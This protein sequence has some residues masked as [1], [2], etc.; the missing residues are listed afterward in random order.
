M[1]ANESIPAPAAARPG[2]KRYIP[3][4][5]IALGATAGI[6]FL[7][8][9]LSFSALEENYEAL[10]AW[11]DSNFLI[12]ALVFFLAYVVVVAFSIPGA[13]WL[14]LL[15]G[16]LFGL[17]MGTA[18]VIGSATLGAT[19]IFLAARTSL[20]ALLKEKAGK[21]IDRMEAEF[22]QGEVSFLLILRLVP[23]VPFFVANLAPAFLG[24]RLF[25]FVWTT[26]IGIIPGTVVFIS[27]GSG[28][29]EQLALGEQPDLSV[30]FE[31]HVLGPLLGLSALASL[32]LVLKK[33]GI[34][35]MRRDT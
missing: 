5:V 34:T 8:D 28:L 3:I 35:G 26:L 13:I 31:P 16:F 20:G 24:A 19:L 25:T 9:Y 22:R 15:G 27:I 1:S 2:W 7:G 12:S 21:W 14:T 23:A 18:L 33:M 4:G 17:V 29:G 10:I 11:R 6:V 32:P 30:I